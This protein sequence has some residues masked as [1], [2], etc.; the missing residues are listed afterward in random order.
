MPPGTRLACSSSRDAT[1]GATLSAI[2]SQGELCARS[3][4]VRISGGGRREAGAV[5]CRPRKDP[6]AA[7]CAL[8]TA[9]P[10]KIQ[11]R[12]NNTA[13]SG[14]PP[15]HGVEA[16]ARR[17]RSSPGVP[18]TARNMASATELDGQLKALYA[19]LECVCV[20]SP[21]PWTNA[22]ANP[23][24]EGTHALSLPLL[25]PA[26]F[27]LFLRNGFGCLKTPRARFKALPRANRARPS[28]G[29]TRRRLRRHCIRT[30]S[31]DVPAVSFEVKKQ[32]AKTQT[33]TVCPP[34]LL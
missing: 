19:Q 24:A 29:N 32:I 7:P 18:Q 34:F 12:A 8:P 25:R 28:D 11:V 2:S 23:E 15:R 26:R 31:V 13:P 20:L 4:E 30:V 21:H 3:N 1:V 9:R 17:A 22:F 16:H 5:R 14:P 6:C 27:I 10:C 33:D